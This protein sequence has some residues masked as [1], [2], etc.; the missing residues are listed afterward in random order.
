MLFKAAPALTVNELA[1]QI[2]SDQVKS[3]STELSDSVD[4]SKTSDYPNRPNRCKAKRDRKRNL[5]LFRSVW[6]SLN[7]VFP[8]GDTHNRCSRNFAVWGENYEYKLS[9]ELTYRMRLFR[10]RSLVA[11]M[12][13]RCLITRSTRQS[14][15]YVPL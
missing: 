14:S 9:G 3:I 4:S 10:S 15:A 8:T 12:Y 13:T 1:N 6:K 5:S 11:T 2:S 7:D